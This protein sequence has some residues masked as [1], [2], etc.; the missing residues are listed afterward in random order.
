[1]IAALAKNYRRLRSKEARK[2][3]GSIRM[4]PLEQASLSEG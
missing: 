1:M 2:E 3:H 4:S